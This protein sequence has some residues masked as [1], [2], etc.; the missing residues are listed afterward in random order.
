MKIGVVTSR[1]NDEVTFLL[2]KGAIDFLK[3]KKLE[4]QSIRV[5][6]A[7]EIPLACKALFEAGCAGVVACGA[8]IRGE[9]TH[10]E[11]VCNS[12]ER[13]VTQL[14]L[15][16]GKP[17]G[18]GVITVENDEQAADRCGGR[19]GNKGT[20]AAQVV[21]EMLGLLEELRSR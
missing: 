4:V 21:V 18:F 1:F 20:E 10:Y 14:M 5:P 19:H 15:E 9:T 17:I 13:G 12:V 8:V 7:V 6:G 3:S 2:E 16:T 11:L